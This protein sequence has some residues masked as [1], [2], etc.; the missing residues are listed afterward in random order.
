MKRIYLST[1][2]IAFSDYASLKKQVEEFPDFQLGV[3]YATSWTAPDFFEKLDA[4]I[5]HMRGI[6][7]TIHSPFVEIC[8]VP[9]S[10]EEKRMEE[11]FTRACGYYKAFHATSMVFHTNEGAFPEEEKA[12]KR[13]RVR[14]V[15][16]D[17]HK[18]L[19][20]QGI[21]MTVENVGYPKKSNLLFDYDQFI[22]LFQELPE[23]I[24]CLI[25]TGHAML[26]G[27]DIVKLIE[28]LGPRIRGYHLNNNDGIHD[29]H[30]PLYDPEGIYSPEQVDE[31]LRAIAC[32]SPDAD[33]GIEY[34]PDNRFTQESL[35][36]DIRRIERV[37][38]D[39]RAKA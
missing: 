20:A 2:G 22:G 18:R 8:T 5:E 9:G 39:C 19:R 4:Q 14:E 24:G 16:L 28:T 21:E 10:E 23:E 35:Y 3:E 11:A 15:L 29:S 17:W 7:A 36:E 25:D 32:Y 12:A 13:A 27:W 30:Y 6:P 34:A 33:L 37:T 1:Y 31:V 38:R 26:N